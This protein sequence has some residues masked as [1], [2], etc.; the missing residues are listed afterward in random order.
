MKKEVQFL[1]DLVGIHAVPVCATIL[2]A[3]IKFTGLET[4]LQKTFISL[5]TT[6]PS[7]KEDRQ[8]RPSL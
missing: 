6:H 5:G 1:K 3:M 8:G 7:K 4:R 2:H